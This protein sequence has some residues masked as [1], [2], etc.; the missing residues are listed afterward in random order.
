MI[1]PRAL[2]SGCVW[3]ASVKSFKCH[4]KSILGGA[5]LTNE[6]LFTVVQQIERIL[7]SRPLNPFSAY[8]DD[9]GVLTLVHFLINKLLISIFEPYL[10]NIRET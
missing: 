7:N 6:E 1:P 9:F 3:E 2:Y 4:F 8:E 10:T 5:N